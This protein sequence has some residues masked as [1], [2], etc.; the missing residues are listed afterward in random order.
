[1]PEPKTIE[2]PFPPSVNHYWRSVVVKNRPRVLISKKGREYRASVRRFVGLGHK[3]MA[4]RLS[5]SVEVFPPDRRKRDL[6]NMLKALLDSMT[7]AGLWLDD[8]Q[9]DDVRIVRRGAT[10]GGLMRVVVSEIGPEA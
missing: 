3:P 4:G 10:A 2:L 8:D 6:D 9:I 7:H 5:V 1:M